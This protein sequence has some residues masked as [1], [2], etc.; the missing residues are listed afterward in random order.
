V[1]AAEVYFYFSR[2]AHVKRR[3]GAA[4]VWAGDAAARVRC[5]CEPRAL[6]AL[7]R[8]RSRAGGVCVIAGSGGWSAAADAP[9]DAKPVVETETED[10]AEHAKQRVMGGSKH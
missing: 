1:V 6:W 8:P 5:K 9:C 3:R 2:T 7:P 4:A 10:G